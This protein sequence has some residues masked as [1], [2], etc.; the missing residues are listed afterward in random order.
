MAMTRT[1]DLFLLCHKIK[2]D[3][4]VKLTCLDLCTSKDFN[5]ISQF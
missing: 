2:L 4:M 5:E 1:G 3:F